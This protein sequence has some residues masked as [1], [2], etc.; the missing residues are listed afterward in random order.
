MADHAPQVVEA[1]DPRTALF[2]RL[3]YFPTPPWAA[4]AGGELIRRL[5]PEARTAWEPACGEGHMAHGLSD[6]FEHVF[7]SDIHDHGSSLQAGAVVDFLAR[8][9]ADFPGNGAD[10]VVTNPPFSQAAAFVEAGLQYARRGVAVLCRLAWFETPG[11]YPLF[12]PPG[13]AGAGDGLVVYAPFFERVCMLLGRWEPGGSTATAAAWFVFMRPTWIRDWEPAR[14]RRELG[15][16]A[17]T[18]P[19]GPGT[20]ARLTRPDDAA[21]FGARGAMPL[22]DAASGSGPQGPAERQAECEVES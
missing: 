1:D 17:L 5:D 9:A 8:E 4:R 11:R 21:R 12:F 22:F 10:W 19:I 20:K 16:C 15:P 14:A 3:N 7:C 2:R 6:Y 13:A 18:V